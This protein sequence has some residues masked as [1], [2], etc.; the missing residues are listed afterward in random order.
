[1]LCFDGE[2]YTEAT[3]YGNFGIY[4]S[5]GKYCGLSTRWSSDYLSSD[6][7]VFIS[8]VGIKDRA[9]I[10][11]IICEAKLP[12]RCGTRLTMRQ[13]FQMALREDIQVISVPFR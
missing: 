13:H 7:N 10:L 6:S 12:M 9:Y 4:L 5:N 1:M 11:R 2:I 3:A 8:P